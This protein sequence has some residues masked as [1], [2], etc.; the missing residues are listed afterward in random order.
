MI[1]MQREKLGP[2]VLILALTSLPPPRIWNFQFLIK[3]R[4]H[5]H[6]FCSKPELE[7]VPIHIFPIFVLMFFVAKH[8]Y[9][10]YAL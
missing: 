8:P 10:K 5:I 6:H 1:E 4:N 3:L 2:S 9:Q 7:S